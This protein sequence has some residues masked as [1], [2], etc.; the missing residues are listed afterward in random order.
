MLARRAVARWQPRFGCH[1]LRSSLA[2]FR[3]LS[4]ASL[5]RGSLR[6]SPRHTRKIWEND[7][8][9]GEIRCYSKSRKKDDTAP[10]V[11]WVQ[12]TDPT[13]T[14]NVVPEAQED[15]DAL[16]IINQA[17]PALDQ[18][19]LH[20]QLSVDYG[21]GQLTLD[22]SSDP[23]ADSPDEL[24]YRDP[25]AIP[26]GLV[27]DYLP[28]PQCATPKTAEMNGPQF[29]PGCGAERHSSEETRKPGYY[30]PEK[31]MPAP[32]QKSH[33]EQREGQQR[34][35]NKEL[36]AIYHR[37]LAGMTPEVFEIMREA[38]MLDQ[39]HAP[40]YG[41]RNR[42]PEETAALVE[43]ENQMWLEALDV[44]ALQ[45]AETP[46]SVPERPFVMCSRCRNLVHHGKLLSDIPDAS[47]T[48][49]AKVIAQSPF[50]RIHIYHVLD[51]ADFPMS[52]LPNA[53]K[54]IL[55]ALKS[56]PGGNKKDVTMSYVITRADLLMP[57]EM[58]VSSLMTYFRR[59]LSEKLDVGDAS[60]K[61]LRV[62]SAK[63]V[64]TTERLKDEVR[65]RKGGVY[66]LGKTN[67]GKSRLYEAIFP[68]KGRATVL[69][70]TKEFGKG[71]LDHPVPAEEEGEE[72]WYI[73][74][75]HKVRYPDMPLSHKTPG[76]TVGAIAID[77]A[78]GRGQLVDLPGMERRGI[79]EHINKNHIAD[80]TLLN[81]KIPERF[82]LKSYQT[83]LVGG[84]VTVKA[85]QPEDQSVLPIVLEIAL[86]SQ[87]PG[88]CGKHDKVKGFLDPTIGGDKRRAFMW[89]M[90]HISQVMASAGVFTLKDDITAQRCKAVIDQ[91]PDFMKTAQFRVYATDIVIEGC[92]WLEISAQIPKNNPLPQIEV[93]SPYGR[94]VEQRETMKAYMENLRPGASPPPGARPKKSMKGAK[95]AEKNELRSLQERY[96]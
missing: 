57:T 83:F 32:K 41:S 18:G 36:D 73:Q 20:P 38:N 90:P 59:V 16:D 17:K 54:N 3:R 14:D 81:R 69:D 91:N 34:M 78:A 63:R 75:G 72:D 27:Y 62:V 22:L 35:L 61:D 87:L 28:A 11:R 82:V 39:I 92:G 71:D 43:T 10:T 60:L 66:L 64:W 79:L 88:H 26:Q 70:Q 80:V 33:N 8:I 21:D 13:K 15:E 86:F 23:V 31:R 44:E 68:K 96:G 2:V 29:C 56:F 84:L 30:G 65:G 51:A 67:V 94:G 50:T 52:L 7:T 12:S 76:T 6:T 47:F 49:I 45:A 37:T 77:F 19:A 9:P 40:K 58:Q 74:N 48:H 1:Y 93:H 5:T 85:V 24:F 95:Q 25:V 42:S 46:E 89:T 53:R 4:T 55:Y